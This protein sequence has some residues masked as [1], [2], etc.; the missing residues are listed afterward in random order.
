L[1][2]FSDW[3]TEKIQTRNNAIIPESFIAEQKDLQR[4]RRRRGLR[5]D[6]ALVDES[7]PP[8]PRS[9]TW[10]NVSGKSYVTPAKNQGICG[11]CYVFAALG[12]LESQILIANK[13]EQS[14]SEGQVADC[15]YRYRTKNASMKQ[16]QKE[17]KGNGCDGGFSPQVFDYIKEVGGITTDFFYEY[18]LVKSNVS[19]RCSFDE[20]TAVQDVNEHGSVWKQSEQLLKQLVVA[21]GP[22]SC[23]PTLKYLTYNSTLI[24]GEIIKGLVGILAHS[25]N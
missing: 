2:K 17:A 21:K 1:N 7:F 16:R 11:S 22:V 20:D 24:T 25:F 23:Q 12:A 10:R 5:G 3:S 6:L 8:P 13:F 4:R 15:I 14:F 18:K 9:Y 19:N